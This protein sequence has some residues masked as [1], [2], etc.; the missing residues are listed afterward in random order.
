MKLKLG[1][2][3]SAGIFL[4]KCKAIAKLQNVKHV[5]LILRTGSDD[6]KSVYLT[7]GGALYRRIH[8][9]QD[10]ALYRRI[11]LTQDGALYRRIHLTQDG[12]L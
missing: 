5:E 9:T 10:G 6:V 1:Y 11:H 7:K 12:A 2:D 4:Y 8:L 3:F